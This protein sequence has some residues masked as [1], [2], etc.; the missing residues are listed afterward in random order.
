MSETSKYDF[1]MEELASLEKKIYTFIQRDVELSEENKRL[2]KRA[3][4]LETEN[5]ILN[6]KLKEVE[7]KVVNIQDT[8]IVSNDSL[9]SE[10][11]ERIKTKIDDLISKIDYHLRS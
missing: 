5:E 8:E 11:K 3:Q 6:L 4:Q 10:E 2:V 1:F 9:N 7:E